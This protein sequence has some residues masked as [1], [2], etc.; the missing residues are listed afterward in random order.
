MKPHLFSAGLHPVVQPQYVN[1]MPALHTPI[2]PIPDVPQPNHYTTPLDPVFV[3]HSG[4]HHGHSIA[5]MTTAGK[6]EGNLTGVA[7]D[8]I[9][10]E[11]SDGKALHIRIAQIVYFDGLPISYR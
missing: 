6:V 7:V 9:Q 5:V 10:L 8:H 3:D 1:Q 11:T 2:F 4:K